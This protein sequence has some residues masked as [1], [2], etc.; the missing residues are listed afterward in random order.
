MAAAFL[1]N[2]KQLLRLIVPKALLPQT[3]QT[4]QTRLGGLVGREIRHIPFTRRTPTT[5]NMLNLYSSHHH[6]MHRY[7]GIIL[8]APEHILSYKLSGLQRLADSRITEAQQL[9]QFQSW[10]ACTC[11]DILDESDFTLAVKTQLIYPSGPQTSVD[12][13]PYR[14]EVAQMLLSLIESHLPE[15]QHNLPQSIAVVKRLHGFPMVC[16]LNTGAEKILQ[17]RL[18]DDICEGRTSL[19]RLANSTSRMNK[20]EIKHVLSKENIDLELIKRV[21]RFFVDKNSSFKKI[22]LVR[23]LLLNK[24]LLLCLKKRWNV[25]YGLHPNRDPI[26]VPFE[27]KGVPSARAEFGHP[28]VAIICTCLAFYH[29]GLNH[30]QLSECLRH[31]LKCDDPAAEYDRWTYGSDTL[32]EAFHHWNVINVDDHEQ[33]EEI[34]RYLRF[35]R[36][37]LDCYMNNYVFPIHAKQ[38]GVKMQASG[39]DLPLFSA[40]RPGQKRTICSVTT[41]FSGTND[42]KVMLPLTIQQDDLP[43]LRQINA[44]VLTYLLQ[45]RNRGYELAAS[46]TKRLTEEELLRKIARMGIRIL[47]NAD[48]YVLE[49]D[50]RS[51]V[52]LWLSIDTKAKGAIYFE[53]DNRAWVQYRGRKEKV[54]LLTSPFVENFDECLVYLDEA[55]TRGVDLKLPK[56]AREAL[57]LALGQTKNHIV[58]GKRTSIILSRG[59]I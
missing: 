36:F 8:T 23:G 9:I 56:N 15:L 30:S 41:G 59:L 57:T 14:W 55:H 24:I 52:K 33:L 35:N 22:L 21:S 34:W 43:S 25:Q 2:K 3:A 42:N 16:F 12:G 11:R 45:E 28:D 58:Q 51:F 1:A 18:I 13:H 20:M 48:A 53:A 39:W 4:V 38:F 10:L 27:A 37:A 32:P 5:P 26:A 29:S 19:L 7:C 6:E 47:I 49:M 31:L 46:Q 17:R 54:S 50:N 40:R 44:E